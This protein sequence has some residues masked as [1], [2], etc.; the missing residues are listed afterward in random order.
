MAIYLIS[1]ILY[2]AICF[3]GHVFPIH[4]LP[5]R[6]AWEHFGVHCRVQDAF[7]EDHHQLLFSQLGCGRYHYFDILCTSRNPQLPCRK[8]SMGLGICW[9]H[10]A[11]LPPSKIFIHYSISNVVGPH[12][13]VLAMNQ[14][15]MQKRWSFVTN[16]SFESSFRIYGVHFLH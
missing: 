6:I 9:L 15:K 11:D 12:I 8:Q 1:G 2:P 10:L 5:C 13:K 7:H 4:R 16:S 3:R 14:T